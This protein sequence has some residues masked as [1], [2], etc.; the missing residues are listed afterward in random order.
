MTGWNLVMSSSLVSA[1][2]VAFSLQ[3]YLCKFTEESIATGCT[4]MVRIKRGNEQDLKKAVAVVGP[5]TAAVD[6]RHT[7]FQVGG[8][9]AG[10]VLIFEGVIRL[11][12]SDKVFEI[13][14]QCFPPPPLPFI[15]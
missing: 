11:L 2:M 14:L 8:A 15:Y 6:S 3:Q 4:G 9:H 1:V 12:L 7:S 13:L 5:V 10:F